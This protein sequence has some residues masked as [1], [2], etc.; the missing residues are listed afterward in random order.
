LEAGISVCCVV[1]LHN[2]FKYK[3][4]G[5]VSGLLLTAINF[6]NITQW[7][8]F[9]NVDSNKKTETLMLESYGLTGVHLI[10]AIICWFF[11]FHRPEE[12]ELVL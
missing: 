3:Y 10:L 7:L 2:W 9:K 6:E 1:T 5:T 11:F 4:I 12:R 8:I